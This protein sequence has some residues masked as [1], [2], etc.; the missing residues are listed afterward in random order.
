MDPECHPKSIKRGTKKNLENIPRKDIK[1]VFRDYYVNIKIIFST[2][3]IKADTKSKPGGTILV[4][5]GNLASNVIHT[6]T[7]TL[8]RWCNAII[9]LKQQRLSVFSI[10][11]TPQASAMTTGPTTIYFQQWKLIC[12][13]GILSPK[14]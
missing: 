4:I 10:Y 12:M 1:N 8:G 2:T 6:Y 11:N 5:T 7:D 3:G 14:P 9:Q 13:K